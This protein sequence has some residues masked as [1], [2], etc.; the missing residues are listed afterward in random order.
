MAPFY[1]AAVL[2]ASVFQEATGQAIQ[3]PDAYQIQT[4]LLSQGGGKPQAD[5]FQWAVDQPAVYKF[6]FTVQQQLLTDTTLEV[7]YSSTRGTHNTRGNMLLNTTPV[8]EVPELGGQ[9]IF[10]EQPLPNPHWDRMRWRMTDGLSW[11]HALLLTGTKR[12]S[13]GFQVQSAYT[14]SKSLDDSSTFSGSSDFGGQDQLGIRREHRWGR[15]SFD[16][17]HS[18]ST[19]FLYELPG[20]NLAGIA[21]KILGGWNIS[22]I[23][24]AFSGAPVTPGGSRSSLNRCMNPA[25]CAGG[26]SVLAFRALTGSGGNSSCNDAQR[27]NGCVTNSVTYVAGGT[28]SLAPGVEGLKINPGSREQYFNPADLVRPPTFQN[29]TAP[30]NHPGAGRDGAP[31]GLIGVGN[32]GRGVLTLPGTLNFDLTLRKDTPMPMLGESGTMEFRFEMF[33]AA[34][35]P[36]LGS[37]GTTLFNATGQPNVNAGVIQDARGNP[38]QLQLSLRLVF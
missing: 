33:N 34:N 18:W 4:A 26:S 10:V 24:R 23:L 36:R 32:I 35:H 25:G 20:R 5:G 3:F 1:S 11:Y 19:N 21:G 12:F 22:G 38:R 27:Q 16:V 29:G 30:V 8:Y 7:G 2:S 37:P 31:G 13:R 15:S 28:V 9:F 17:S 6:S 14:W